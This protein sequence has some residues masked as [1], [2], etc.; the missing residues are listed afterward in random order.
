MSEWEWAMV[1]D[2]LDAYLLEHMDYADLSEITAYA[3]YIDEQIGIKNFDPDGRW[4][5]KSS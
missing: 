2:A 1:S 4:N 3:E 5:K